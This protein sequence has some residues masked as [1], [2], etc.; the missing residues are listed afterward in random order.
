M[1]PHDAAR[2]LFLRHAG[3]MSVLGGSAAPLLLNLSAAGS[4]LAQSVSVSTSD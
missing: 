3:A 2:R 4:A 1:N